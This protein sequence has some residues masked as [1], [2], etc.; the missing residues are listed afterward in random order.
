MGSK[1]Y[2]DIIAKTIKQ[3]T[4]YKSSGKKFK[5]ILNDAIESQKKLVEKQLI[6]NRVAIEKIIETAGS[7]I[8]KQISEKLNEEK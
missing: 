4:S 1:E 5:Q 8:Q 6:Q 7:E 3:K 2:R